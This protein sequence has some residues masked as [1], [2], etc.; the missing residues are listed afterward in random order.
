[1]NLFKKKRMS[2]LCEK[3]REGEREGGREGGKRK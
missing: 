2:R 1:M 3:E